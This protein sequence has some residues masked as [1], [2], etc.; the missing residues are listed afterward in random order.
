MPRPIDPELEDRI[1]RAARKLW[2]NGG[3]KA[4]SMRAVAKAAKTNT[5]AVYR[6]FRDRDDILR[7]L[8]ESFQ[9][10]ILEKVEVCNSLVE[11]VHCYLQFALERPREYELMMSGLL[12][13]MTK[14]RPTLDFVIKKSSEWLGGPPRDH[15]GL[16]FIL[17]A[18]VQGT[19]ISRI[20]GFISEENFGV[21]QAAFS[22]AVEVLI[23]NEE[24]LRE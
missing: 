23:A 2:R 1:L 17:G 6:R 24:K 18:L 20:A 5:P 8:V 14:S 10:E 4:L 15:R 12:P 11:A 22:K 7:A 19:A 21:M 13:R 16:V 3:E 9:K